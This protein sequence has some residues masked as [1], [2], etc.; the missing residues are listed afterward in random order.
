MTRAPAKKAQGL[1]R[2][3]GIYLFKDAGGK[4]VYVGKAKS[5]RDRVRS[6]FSKG[7]DERHRIS[8]LLRRT[9]DIDF[10]VTDTEKEALLLE[11][12]LIKRHR[13]RYNITL[14]DDKGYIS[15]RVGRD[16]EYP[17]ITLTR[18]VVDDG[19]A[20]FGP[21]DSAAAAREA[22]EQITRCF[23]LRTCTD[24][25]F[26]NRM[27]PCLEFDIGRCAA[28]C[29]RRVSPE[30]YNEQVEEAELFLAGRSR[31]LVGRL[32][33]RMDEASK[34]LRYEYAARLRDAIDMIEGVAEKQKVIRHGGGDVDAIGVAKLK[35]E[36]AICVLRVRSGVLIGRRIVR[37]RRSFGDDATILEEFLIQ[38]YREKTEIPPFIA[39]SSRPESPRA[40]AGILGERRKGRVRLEIPSRGDKARLVALAGTNARETLA[41]RAGSGAVLQILERIGR[42]LGMGHAPDVI[43]CVD[44]SNLGGREA[45]GSLATFVEGEP[46]K[47]RYRIYNIRTIAE[48]DD[49]GMMCEVLSRRFGLGRPLRR[50]SEKTAAGQI[51]PVPDLL[52]VDGGKGQLA[53]ATRV[54]G[55]LGVRVHAAAIAK[56]QK[57]GEPDRIFVPGRKNPLKLKSRSKELLLLMRMRDEAHR[58]GISA[59]RRRRG[60]VAMASPL[61]EIRGLGPT[62]RRLLLKR[63]GG[64]DGIARASIEDISSVPGVTKDMA[65]R[66]KSHNR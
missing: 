13:P 21:Y 5:L 14:R 37:S 4:V 2:K 6:Y 61:E 15:I 62:R 30:D 11:N 9:K 12:T 52:L 56:G 1:P 18:R 27:R 44:I 17:G 51:L 47:G 49:Y 57:K 53:I 41:A 24:R 28:P 39:I 35:D 66:I 60:R 58:F 23:L 65:R 64:M 29:A 36:A 55:E 59:H 46:D 16:R 8:F 48:P 34:G 43:E 50:A 10:I 45:V 3:P 54:L 31:E 38:H 22:V 33:S 63:F 42:R 20:Y 25:E 7:R 40:I 26:A 19:A 32:K